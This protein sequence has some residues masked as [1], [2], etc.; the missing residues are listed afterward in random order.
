MKAIV[1]E[2]ILEAAWSWKF[3]TL[4]SLLLY[5]FEIFHNEKFSVNDYL[6][7]HLK[8]SCVPP[9]VHN[10]LEDTGLKVKSK[11]SRVR[12]TKFE[13]CF[14][15]SLVDLR[16]VV[17]PLGIQLPH[18]KN[19]ALTSIEHF[20]SSCSV[21][22]LSHFILPTSLRGKVLLLVLFHRWGSSLNAGDWT[23]WSK[24]SRT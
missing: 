7:H 20:V 18:L 16:Q 5:V 10:P 9:S 8:L 14:H 11:G 1:N 3:I 15:Q 19:Q 17:K 13:S 24:S 4:S 6:R 22:M 2:L 23:I 21:L 12:L